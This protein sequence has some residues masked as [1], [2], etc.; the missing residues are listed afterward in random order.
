MNFKDINR[1][2]FKVFTIGIFLAVFILMGIDIRGFTS[3]FMNFRISYIPVILLF[4]L[5]NYILRFIKWNYYLRQVDINIPIKDSALIFAAALPM[6]ITPGKIGEFIKSYMLKVKYE[7]PVTL[8]SPVVIVERLTDSIGMVILTAVGVLSFNFGV[9]F[10]II[11][12]LLIILGMIILQSKKLCY[13]TIGIISRLTIIKKYVP[14]LT[15]F[16]ESICSVLKVR[17]LIT[18]T[19]IGIVAWAFEGFV[20]YFSAKGAGANISILYAI[21]ILALSSIAGAISMIPGGIVVSE[22]SILAMLLRTGIQKGVAGF[23]SFIIR[24]AT[25]W[26]GVIV[27]SFVLLKMEKKLFDAEDL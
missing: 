6:T 22:G 17:I 9:S 11:T 8:T 21:F 15:N 16:Y 27:G 10:L 19:L 24:F 13:G 18:A 5:L 20:V 25:L 7:Y 4:I 26:L 2:I 14:V 23:I 1:L 3:A 12:I